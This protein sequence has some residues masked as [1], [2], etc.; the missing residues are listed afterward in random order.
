[1]RAKKILVTAIGL[2]VGAALWS[3]AAASPPTTI[4][5]ATDYGRRA[6][7]LSLPTGPPKRVAVFYLYPTVTEAKPERPDGMRGR[8]PRHGEGARPAFARQAG[9]SGPSPTSTRR[10]TGRPMSRRA[11]SLPP[12]EQDEVVAGEPT[13]RRDRC[14]R[15][16]H[17][18]LQRRPPVHPRVA[19][20]RLERDGEPARELHEERTRTCRRGWSPRTSSATRSRR[21]TWPQNPNL[22][23]AESATDTGVI[24]S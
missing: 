17:Q 20:A 10:T 6:H 4:L 23:F 2:L 11:R 12:A 8:R 7:W 18:A 14:L 1:M 22:K 16:L 5:K 21:P 19:L 13:Q 15:L 24:V 9:A 3:T